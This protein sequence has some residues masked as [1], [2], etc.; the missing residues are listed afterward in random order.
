MT[1]PLARCWKEA[2]RLKR[3]QY[4]AEFVVGRAL[5]DVADEE[6]LARLA[7]ALRLA[8]LHL[9]VPPLHVGAVQLGH[10]S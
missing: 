3:K 6:L 8:L 4:L 5:A 9:D 1:L 10:G 7:R 2:L